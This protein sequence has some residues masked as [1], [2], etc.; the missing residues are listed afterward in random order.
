MIVSARSR[1]LA[2][3]LVAVL[4]WLSLDVPAAAAATYPF[5]PPAPPAAT[6]VAGTGVALAWDAVEGAPGYRVRYSSRS[7]MAKS[8]YLRTTSPTAVV[9]GLARGTTYYVTVRVID[10]DGT[11]LSAYS[12]RY[13]VRTRTKLSYK[14]LV[15]GG[16]AATS[17]NWDRL[18]V[19]WDR[20]GPGTYRVRWADNKEMDGA[21]TK[22]VRGTG[23]TITGLDAATT[24]Y[25]QVKVVTRTAGATRSPY[26]EAVETTTADPD[27]ATIRV[28]SYNVKCANCTGG[29]SWYER[30]DAVV[31]TILDQDLDVIGAQ[32][33]S[34]AWLRA[35][36]GAGAKINLA[37]FEDLVNRLGKPY[38]LANTH[39]NN[40]VNST[41]PTNCVYADRGAS[42]D[43]KII[44]DSSVLTL[45]DQG[46]KLLPEINESDNDRYVAWAIFL[47]RTSGQKFFFAD[48]HLEYRK[49][50]GYY[51]LRVAQTE[52]LLDVVANRNPGLPAYIV[53]DF[54]SHKWSS[55]DNAPRTAVLDAGFIDP[56]GNFD[57]STDTTRGAIVDKRIHTNVNTLNA[58][59]PVARHTD[60]INGSNIDY[61]FTSPGIEVPEWE[62]VVDIDDEYNFVGMI[63][64]D[65]NLIRATTVLR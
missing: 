31:Q 38:K 22:K 11:S 2:L 17:P 12:E 41:T 46:S 61:I 64:S 4:A 53:G 47:H 28:G 39:R 55:P 9:T 60:G 35:D 43:S 24:Y 23:Y 50:D 34:Q 59:E 8:R 26:S 15:P 36:D 44:Y 27:P 33:A 37:Q 3:A 10:T 20:S 14:Y 63:P 21:S 1:R 18:A 32:E 62:T 6:E 7:S 19:S 29:L 40:C 65:H 42:Q 48:T 57:E 16:L 5:E 58:Y 25:L 56:L 30:R 45:L 13:S 49:D 52:K 54:N 51:E